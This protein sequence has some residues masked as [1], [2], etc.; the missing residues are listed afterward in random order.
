MVQID[1]A[2]FAIL[3]SVVLA[4]IALAVAWGALGQTVKRHD[5]EIDKLH[6]ENREDH[7]AIFNKL[8]E[9]NRSLK[10]TD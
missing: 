9:I 8:E 7:R 3:I 10:R 5:K 1:T 4:I 2:V 6:N